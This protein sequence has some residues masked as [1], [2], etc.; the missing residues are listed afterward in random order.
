AGV[1]DEAHPLDLALEELVRRDGGPVADGTD[2]V[3]V[4]VEDLEDLRDA[5]EET[6]RRVARRRG[7]LR[8]DGRPRG[9][10]EGDDIGERPARVDPD[11]DVAVAFHLCASWLPWPIAIPPRRPPRSHGS[12]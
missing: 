1:G 7:G 6:V 10:V 5:G 3:G 11:P 12:D 8:R 4:E 9:L 2:R